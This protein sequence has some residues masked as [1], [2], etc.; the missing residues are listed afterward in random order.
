MEPLPAIMLVMAVVEAALVLL[1]TT[2]WLLVMIPL[3]RVALF[4]R[5]R[6]VPGLI[7]VPPT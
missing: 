3:P 1:K 4:E 2:D 7:R 6:V 5:I